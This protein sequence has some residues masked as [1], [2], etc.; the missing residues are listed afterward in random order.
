MQRLGLYLQVAVNPARPDRNIRSRLDRPQQL[1]CILNG[2]GIVC[3]H[4]ED[5]IAVRVT[6]AVADALALSAID[7]IFNEM[8]TGCVAANPRAT[9][10]VSSVDPSLTTI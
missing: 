6:D 1:L 3:V 2:R 7:R 8:Y 9:S 5:N 4:E 10:A